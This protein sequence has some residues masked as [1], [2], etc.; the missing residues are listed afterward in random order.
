MYFTCWPRPDARQLLEVLPGA[1]LDEGFRF[2]GGVLHGER[3]RQS[4]VHDVN[5]EEEEQHVPKDHQGP[6]SGERLGSEDELK[7]RFENNPL[8]LDLQ[9]FLH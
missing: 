9:A 2:D 3:R 8:V 5:E 6:P 7:I 4:L 1:L